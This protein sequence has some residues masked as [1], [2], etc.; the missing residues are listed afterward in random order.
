MNEHLL[1]DLRTCLDR[2]PLLRVE[3]AGA[4]FRATGTAHARVGCR[5]EENGG[6]FGAWDWDGTCC[7]VTNDRLGFQPLFYSATDTTFRVSSSLVR[8]IEDGAPVALDAEA[9]AVFFRLGFFIGEGTPFRHI[10]QLPPGAELTWDGTLRVRCTPMAAPHT[11]PMARSELVGVYAEL[12]HQSV[13]R[14]LPGGKA[15]V[16][17][18]SGGRDSR[19]ILFELVRQGAAPAA[20]VT[21][22]GYPPKA[23]ET[24]T[25]ARVAAA[26][27]VRHVVLGEWPRLEAELARNFLFHFCTDEHTWAVP[28]AWRMPELGQVNYDGIGGGILTAGVFARRADTEAIRAGRAGRVAARLLRRKRTALEEVLDTG[29]TSGAAYDAA[30]AAVEERLT[31]YADWESPLTA[32]YFWSRTRREVALTPGSLYVQMEACHTPYLAPAM[33]DLFLGLP[34]ESLDDHDLHNAVL[35]TTFPQY[36]DVP[37][38]PKARRPVF[39]HNLELARA[40]AGFARRADPD[41]WKRHGARV[42][43]NWVPWFAAPTRWRKQHGWRHPAQLLYAIQLGVFARTRRLE[44][45]LGLEASGR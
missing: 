28:L 36:A 31:A 8:L 4:E 1:R 24:P 20:C 10:R 30:H 3:R 35:R 26:V 12:F 9:L 2:H 45:A 34:P 37:F 44:A 43:T 16:I 19:H 41:W 29:L 14:R 40:V 23:D 11:A 38:L 25:A 6:L 27:G 5:V 42:V 33:V 13:A 39:R 15:G 32:F 22:T 21:M 7:R 17:T 18:L